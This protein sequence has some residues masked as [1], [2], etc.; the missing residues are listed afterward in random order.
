MR[1]NIQELRLKTG[2]SQA[3][4]A[5]QYGIPVSTLRKWE[6]GETNIAPYVLKLIAATV[7]PADDGLIK[8][9]SKDGK[10]YYY[11]E[12]KSLLLDGSGNS[13]K[14]ELE[15]DKINPNNLAM[16]VADLFSSIEDAKANFVSDLEIDKKFKINWV[17]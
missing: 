6:Q 4:F 14:I 13:V 16:Y 8:I 2:L 12:N 1:Y 15:C 10:T 5:K 9:A 7:L 3:A 17:R 11:D